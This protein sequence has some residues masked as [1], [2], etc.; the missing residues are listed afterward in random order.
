MPWNTRYVSTLLG[1]RKHNINNNRQLND[2]SRTEE[3]MEQNKTKT[4]TPWKKVN[5][6]NR[7]RFCETKSL[8]RMHFEIIGFWWFYTRYIERV[9]NDW[10]CVRAR[11]SQN[12]FQRVE[13]P[14]III[15]YLP[16]SRSL[17]LA[18]FHCSFSLSLREYNMCVCAV[19]VCGGK[20]ERKYTQKPTAIRLSLK[21]IGA[22]IKYF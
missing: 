14:P 21:I 9:F 19:C 13:Y 15:I 1:A 7:K 8:I 10:W 18:V 20:K 6:H 3:E 5:T 2:N 16:F 12:Y 22:R 4:Q 11:Y 17:S